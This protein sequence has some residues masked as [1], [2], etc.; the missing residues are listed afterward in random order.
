MKIFIVEVSSDMRDRF[1]AQFA[2]I[3]GIE[4]LFAENR[5]E[6]K[7]LFLQHKDEI[8]FVCVAACIETRSKFDTKDL[9]FS[10]Q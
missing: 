8:D 7:N 9:T 4:L 5:N 10:S 1:T 6:G 2:N 3:K